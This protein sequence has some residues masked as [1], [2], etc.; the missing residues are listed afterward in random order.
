MVTDN[1]TARVEY[2]YTDYEDETFNLGGGDVD[3]DLHHAL[4]PRRRRLEVLTPFPQ[5]SAKRLGFV[6]AFSVL[7]A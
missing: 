2:R 1:I 7:A 4:D 6:R 3:S 5:A